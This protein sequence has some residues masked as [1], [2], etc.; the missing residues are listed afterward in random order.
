MAENHFDGFLTYYTIPRNE[1]VRHFMLELNSFYKESTCMQEIV[2][3]SRV[4]AK[5][6]DAFIQYL[7]TGTLENDYFFQFMQN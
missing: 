7:E 2:S 1:M 6:K 3:L 4:S 5:V